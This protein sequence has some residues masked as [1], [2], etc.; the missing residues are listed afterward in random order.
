[1]EIWK[2][3]IEI[4][5]KEW[6]IVLGIAL[7]FFG[8]GLAVIPWGITECDFSLSKTF[9]LAS[10]GSLMKAVYYFG[11]AILVDYL[12][13]KFYWAKKILSWAR[14]RSEKKVTK[15]AQKRWGLLLLIVLGA[16]SLG[17]AA[18]VYLVYYKG[19]L[20]KIFFFSIIGAFASN[21]CIAFFTDRFKQEIINFLWFLCGYCFEL[22]KFWISNPCIELFLRF[23]RQEI[24][25]QTNFLGWF[26][27]EI[28]KLWA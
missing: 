13:E 4:V 25:R 3:L 1:M 20:A 8:K 17:T 6:C 16:T 5:S 21:A 12:A 15:K 19:R 18:G 10:A 28:L 9:F 22:L 2:I 14:N 11:S 23:I 27:L 24:I 7:P 26:C